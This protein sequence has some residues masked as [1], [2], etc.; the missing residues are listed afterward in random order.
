MPYT[1][2][3]P[4]GSFCWIDLATTDVVA[5]ATFYGE[6][7]HWRIEAPAPG[8]EPYWMIQRDDRQIGA[9][10]APTAIP[11]YA[12]GLGAEDLPRWQSYIAVDDVDA[13]TERAVS[14]GARILMEP[15]DAGAAGRVAYLADPGGAVFALW[16]ARGRQGAGE[17][18]AVGTFCCQELHTRDVDASLDFYAGLF[19]WRHRISKSVPGGQYR[20]LSDAEGE[21]RGGLMPI[22]ADWEEY[23]GPVAPNWAVYFGVNDCDETADMATALGGQLKYPIMELPRIGRFAALTDPQGATFWITQFAQDHD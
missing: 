12:P 5:A 6:L 17:T 15:K 23:G 2:T 1:A 21:K 9:L 18:N 19:G 8:K 22:G 10:F 20:L 14:L 16:Q 7:F 11:D 4:T 3:Y 13:R